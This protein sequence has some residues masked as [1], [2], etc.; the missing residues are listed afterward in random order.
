M[1]H[2]DQSAASSSTAPAA[3]PL[4]NLPA[5]GDIAPATHGDGDLNDVHEGEGLFHLIGESTD[6]W[7]LAELPESAHSWLWSDYDSSQ[8]A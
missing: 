2:G 3:D 4:N 7:S 5:F 8:D 1:A 6:G